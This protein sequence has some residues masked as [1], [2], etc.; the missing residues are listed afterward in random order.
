MVFIK[1]I[2]EKIDMLSKIEEIED[3]FLPDGDKQLL[4][5]VVD[6]LSK[7][8][9]VEVKKVKGIEKVAISGGASSQGT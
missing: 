3:R 6:S 8:K 5:Q 4:I 2:L 7:G 1:R 9:K